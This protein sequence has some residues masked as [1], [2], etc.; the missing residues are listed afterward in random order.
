MNV[1]LLGCGDIARAK[2]RGAAWGTRGS[3]PEELLTVT[4]E[5]GQLPVDCAEELVLQ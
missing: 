5:D 1:A 2:E 4:A 3:S